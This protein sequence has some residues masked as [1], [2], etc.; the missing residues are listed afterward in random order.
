MKK[1]YVL[2]KVHLN[3]VHSQ[4]F[5]SMKELKEKRLTSKEFP[6]EIVAEYDLETNKYIFL[7]SIH[8]VPS[9]IEPDLTRIKEDFEK[10]NQS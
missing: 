5:D 8:G 9:I 2:F 4:R 3:E 7:P 1:Q 6:G 10:E